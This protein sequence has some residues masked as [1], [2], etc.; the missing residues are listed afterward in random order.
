MPC[1]VHAATLD[2]IYLA[3]S[4]TMMSCTVHSPTDSLMQPS[5]IVVYIECNP[6]PEGSPFELSLGL[7]SKLLSPTPSLFSQS[8]RVCWF[9]VLWPW[10]ASLE[11]ESKPSTRPSHTCSSSLVRQL[12]PDSRVKK[13]HLHH[14]TFFNGQS[15]ALGPVAHLGLVVSSYLLPYVLYTSPGL[16]LVSVGWLP[17]KCGSKPQ[18]D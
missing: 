9:L 14:F 13:L 17:F 3:P 18:G 7:R 11:L 12:Y 10:V 1:A 8:S 15:L 4:S 5:C 2:V 16:C 6:A